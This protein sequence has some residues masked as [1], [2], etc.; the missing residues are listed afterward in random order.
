MPFDTLLA[1]PQ[2]QYTAVVRVMWKSASF[3]QTCQLKG[4]KIKSQKTTMWKLEPRDTGENV[5]NKCTIL[6]LYPRLEE[7]R[8]QQRNV[9]SF[10]SLFC[11]SNNIE[12]AA[13]VACISVYFVFRTV[14]KLMLLK[15]YMYIS[16]S[17]RNS[18]RQSRH[19]WKRIGTVCPNKSKKQWL[20]G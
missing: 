7:L 4:S 13:L 2:T 14:N 16:L 15:K 19:D 6:P 18:V 8:I 5:P 11:E 10:N 17:N 12:K 9:P 3:L 20:S 1:N